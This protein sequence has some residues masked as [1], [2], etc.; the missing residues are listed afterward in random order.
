MA[1]FVS[2]NQAPD[3]R[4]QAILAT[5]AS[6]PKGKVCTYGRIAEMAGYKGN[7]RYVGHVLRNLPK[8]SSIPWHRV[9]NASGTPSFPEYSDKYHEQL[10]RLSV[11]GVDAV[12]GR[13]NLSRFL[14]Q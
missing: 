8:G 5:L 6:I 1:G 12:K 3:E 13:I 11:E 9:I 10:E 7:A 2:N 14:W 4:Y